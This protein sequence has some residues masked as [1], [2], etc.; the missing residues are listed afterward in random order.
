M[1]TSSGQIGIGGIHTH[2]SISSVSLYLFSRLSPRHPEGMLKVFGRRP[3]AL[4]N[5]WPVQGKQ[6]LEKTKPNCLV[7]TH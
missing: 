1:F 3:K 5:L 6:L 7:L 4:K 2:I